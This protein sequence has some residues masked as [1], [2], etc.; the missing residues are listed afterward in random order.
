MNLFG[1]MIEKK[2][3][4]RRFVELIFV[5]QSY[6]KLIAYVFMIVVDGRKSYFSALTQMLEFIL[7]SYFL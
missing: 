5:T 7:Q 4:R 1:L 6:D 3:T 2:A